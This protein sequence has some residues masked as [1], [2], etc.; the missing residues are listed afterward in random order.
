MKF[1]EQLAS[2]LTPEWRKQYIR[3][4]ELKALLYDIMLEAPTEAD[5]RDQ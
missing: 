2:H 3:Y 5:T 4:E 1:G